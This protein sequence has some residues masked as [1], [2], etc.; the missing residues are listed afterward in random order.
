M[1]NEQTPSLLQQKRPLVS[2]IVTTYNMP[3]QLL[4]E[5]LESIGALGLDDDE[6]EIVLVDDGSEVTPLAELSDWQDR[7]VYLRQQNCGLSVARNNGLRIATCRYIQFVDGDD[8]LLSN[9]YRQCLQWVKEH[10]ADMMLFGL[11][12]QSARDSEDDIAVEGPMTGASYL[13][14]NNLRASACGYLFRRLMLDNLRFTPGIYHEDEEFTP[15][16]LLKAD[17]LYFTEAD[18]YYYRQREESI[19]HQADEAHTRKRLEDM[20]N[21]IYRLQ[22]TSATI[23]EGERVALSRRVAQ[24]SMDY[25]YQTISLTRNK[26]SL[27]AAIKHLEVAGLFPL[28][29]KAY[30]KKYS[31]FR[32]LVGNA[33]GRRL[34]LLF[35][36]RG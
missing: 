22:K 32:R 8:C 18:A 3:H 6:C 19:T 15:L 11:N 24:L 35:A 30:T 12:T 20:R 36:A 1:Q 4:R 28:P 14:N 29:D 31:M 2:F 9:T 34:L 13:H 16:L 21:I 7:M 33:A 10:D 27:D 26:E 25:L 17:Q 23:P 5:C